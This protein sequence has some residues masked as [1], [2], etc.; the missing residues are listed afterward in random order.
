M[1]WPLPK[2]FRLK[3]KLDECLL[4]LPVNLLKKEAKNLVKFK[5]PVSAE[6]RKTIQV[7]KPLKRLEK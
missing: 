5:K 4:K 7:K 1:A 6:F 2:N 3:L